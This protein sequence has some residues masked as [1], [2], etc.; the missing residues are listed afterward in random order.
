MRKIAIIFLSC[1]LGAQKYRLIETVL[2]STHNNLHMF[3]LRNK[4]NNFQLHTLIWEPACHSKPVTLF[5]YT[6]IAGCKKPK[7]LLVFL[8]VAGCRASENLDDF[9]CSSACRVIFL[10]F[11][12]SR[13]FKNQF[14]EKFFKEYHQ[15]VKQ[16]GSRSGPKFCLA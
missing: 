16:F 4:K 7:C 12:V 5:W 10:D 13:L 3:W 1:V 11:F 2:L 8:S 15:G 9:Q 14:F 6:S